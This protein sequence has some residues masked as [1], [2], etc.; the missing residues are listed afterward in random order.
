MDECSVTMDL[1][2]QSM[3]YHNSN[4]H[5]DATP[6][7]MPDD[8]TSIGDGIEVEE[9]DDS[10]SA[11]TDHISKSRSPPCQFCSSVGVVLPA[12]VLCENCGYQY[13]YECLNTLHPRRGPFTTHRLQSVNRKCEVPVKVFL[14]PHHDETNPKQVQVY[15]VTCSSAVCFECTTIKGRHQN[16]FLRLFKEQAAFKMAAVVKLVKELQELESDAKTDVTDMEKSLE[17]L[18]FQYQQESLKAQQM[19]A[20]LQLKILSAETRAAGN[21]K[22]RI[23]ASKGRIRTE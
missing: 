11:E 14:C 6:G 1:K 9:A 3:E 16:H 12:E 20:S 10:R 7:D 18:R 8:K 13:C 17:Q 4:T 23:S 21:P 19:C 22:G 5:G 2:K 15:C